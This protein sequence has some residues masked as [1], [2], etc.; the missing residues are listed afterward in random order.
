LL[1]VPIMHIA[2]LLNLTAPVLS[3]NFLADSETAPN[4]CSLLSELSLDSST[5][6]GPAVSST[7]HAYSFDDQKLKVT[8][9]LSIATSLNPV[10]TK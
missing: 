8:C 2:S 3:A 10:F 7:K 6:R 9:I 1:F 4:I 5:W